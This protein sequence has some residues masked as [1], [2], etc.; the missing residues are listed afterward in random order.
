MKIK[1]NDND[2]KP[3]NIIRVEK[4][5]ENPYVLINKTFLNNS[6]LSWKAKGLLA[7][8]LSKPDDWVVILE[9]LYN[10]SPDGEKSVRSGLNELKENNHMMKFPVYKSGLVHHWETVITEIPFED[11]ERIKSKIILEDG[12]EKIS[13]I[14]SENLLAGN[15]K[16]GI[17]G[18]ENNLLSQNV[19]VGNVQVVN[20]DVEKDVLL[21]NDNIPNNDVLLSNDN[22]SVCLSN[23]TDI[24]TDELEKILEVL[25][26]EE[27]KKSSVITP[28]FIPSIEGAITHMFLSE[29]I[30][31]DGVTVP[32]NLIRKALSKLTSACIEHAYLK[33]DE[34][35]RVT[36]VKNPKKYLQA[37][38][39]NSVYDSD[40]A[41]KSS[42]NYHALGN[43]WNNDNDKK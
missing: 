23:K 40:I 20:V 42:V 13:F 1:D 37:I 11:S 8:L 4:N 18:E 2:K 41:I 9:H 17:D 22:Q 15:G 5:K 12:S 29:S 31:V 43:G 26:S 27:V 10:M 33:F 39:Y 38:V 35:S 6:K 36:E 3:K 30:I 14:N 25:E 28:D 16:V 34:Y 32:N 21:N 7:Y 24:Q 19:Q